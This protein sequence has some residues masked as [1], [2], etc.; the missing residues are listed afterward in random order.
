MKNQG[1]GDISAFKRSSIWK[2]SLPSKLYLDSRKK[3]TGTPKNS[4][5]EMISFKKRNSFSPIKERERRFIESHRSGVNNRM[6]DSLNNGEYG[7]VVLRSNW[8]ELSH[9]EK[10]R[11]SYDLETRIILSKMGSCTPTHIN[12]D[13]SPKSPKNQHSPEK[14]SIFGTKEL[15]LSLKKI[16]KTFEKAIKLENDN[17]DLEGGSYKELVLQESD[18]DSVLSREEMKSNHSE[19]DL[20]SSGYRQNYSEEVKSNDK[21]SLIFLLIFD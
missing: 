5:K 21:F 7:G 1:K 20:K 11:S 15:N 3:L 18:N 17:E 8:K 10:V 4:Y 16:D 19:G 2:T 6:L 9:H 14:M 13:N 12:R